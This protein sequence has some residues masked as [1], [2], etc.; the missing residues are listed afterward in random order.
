MSTIRIQHEDFDVG[1]EADALVNGG[2]DVGAV[3]TFSGHVRGDGGPDC[4]HAGTLSRH[5]GTRD[6]EPCP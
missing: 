1:A 5:D 2:N 4:A 3:V 6:R